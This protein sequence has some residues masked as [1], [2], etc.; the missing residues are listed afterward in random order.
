MRGNA[1]IAPRELGKLRQLHAPAGLRGPRVALPSPAGAPR[2]AP[3]DRGARAIGAG[4]ARSGRETVRH[5]QGLPQR[6]RAVPAVARPGPVRAAG[7]YDRR[8]RIRVVPTQARCPGWHRHRVASAGAALALATQILAAGPLAAWAPGRRPR[9]FSPA[10]A[11][12]DAPSQ[13]LPPPAAPTFGQTSPSAD[14]PPCAAAAAHPAA[15]CARPVVHPV[16]PPGAPAADA[17]ARAAAA[18]E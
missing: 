16:V 10:P 4:R 14:P 5:P 9:A 3:S 1:W 17:A 7:A 13:P 8:A 6:R 11:L 12:R 18:P 2:S 15:G